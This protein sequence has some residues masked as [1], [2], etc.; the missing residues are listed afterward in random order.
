MKEGTLIRLK[1]K[2]GL[3]QRS[4]VRCKARTKAG[5]VCKVPVVEKGLC[6]FHAHAEKRTENSERSCSLGGSTEKVFFLLTRVRGN[7][8]LSE[9]ANEFKSE[10]RDMENLQIRHFSGYGAS[11][12]MARFTMATI[13]RI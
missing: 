4:R 9:D 11:G 7:A 6:F 10:R 13:S 1:P 2:K 5:A 8:G 3:K 12:S